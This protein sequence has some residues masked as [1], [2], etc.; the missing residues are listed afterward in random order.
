MLFQYMEERMQPISL[1]ED[2]FIEEC[3]SAAMGND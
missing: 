3:I 1:V 2:E